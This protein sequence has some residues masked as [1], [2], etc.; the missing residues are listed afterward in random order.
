MIWSA[1]IYTSLYLFIIWLSLAV[2]IG[3]FYCADL[4]EEH[5]TLFGLIIKYSIWGVLVLHVILFFEG[6]LPYSYIVLGMLSHGC[7]YQLLKDYP[8][9]QGITNPWL[10]GSIVMMVIDNACWLWHFYY[11]YFT[12]M[13][14]LCFGQLLL[15]LVP[16]LYMISLSVNDN[17]LPGLGTSGAGGGMG[18]A[19]AG[20]NEVSLKGLFAYF[21]FSSSKDKA[22]QPAKQSYYN[23]H[24]AAPPVSAYQGPSTSYTYG[25]GDSQS[26]MTQRGGGFPNQAQAQAQPHAAFGA[27]R[28]YD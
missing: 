5:P 12:M 1:L 21:G 6:G 19:R 9:V 8:R 28:K 17:V 11:H 15:W 23:P 26:Q 16:F 20:S 24:A 2:T 3:I 25:S 22:K 7:Y 18:S 27:S 10:I 4:A 13:E 14:I